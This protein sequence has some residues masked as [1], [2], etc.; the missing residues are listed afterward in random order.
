MILGVGEK[1]GVHLSYSFGGDRG[2]PTAII[3]LLQAWWFRITSLQ[4]AL[5]VLSHTKSVPQKFRPLPKSCQKMMCLFGGG[6]K[7]AQKW[8]QNLMIL[9]VG[10]KS[11]VHFSY[12]FG[13]D[14]GDPTT[15]I[16][17]LQSW[18]FRITSL[19]G[20]LRVLSHTKSVTHFVQYQ[21][22]VKKWRVFFWGGS[23]KAQK[24]CQNLMILGVGENSGVHLS[25]SFGGDRG[26]S[27]SDN[28]TLTG[29]VIPNT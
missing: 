25:Y 19:Q 3:R 6:S 7:K 27:Y 28:R 29:V 16:I 8:Y 23:K 24:W 20:A 5:R 9:G 12:S 4:G 22:H 17:L 26:G 14:R 13:G 10:E 1:S 11:G 15:I 2:D 18:W 21:N